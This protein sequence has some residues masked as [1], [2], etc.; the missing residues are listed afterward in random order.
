MTILQP[1]TLGEAV[2][3]LGANPGAQIIAGTTDLLPTW[4][5]T[6][7]YPQ[8]AVSIGQ[9]AELRGA[10]ETDGQVTIGAMSTH[11]RIAQD[12]TIQAVAPALVEA[13]RS[14]GAPAVRNMG[15]LGG[16]IVNSSPAA[17][18]PP[19]LLALSADV[20]LR[21]PKGVRVVQLHEFYTGY[22]QTVLSSDEILTHV[23]FVVPQKGTLSRFYKMG[24]RKAQ[25]VSKLSLGGLLNLDDSRVSIIR[26]AVGSMATVPTRLV[27]AESVLEGRALDTESVRECV[28]VAMASVE[29][30]DDVRSSGEYRRKV[31]GIIVEKFLEEAR[32]FRT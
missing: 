10:R 13:A 31:L 17:D 11:A 22:R 9:I 20:H 7:K 3:L 14:V 27:K 28:E 6:G 32:R 2:A 1:K 4:R 5:K 29:P 19:V 18:L 24:A 8:V 16:N 23:S 26:L 21:G 30:I 25:A 12:P 15:T